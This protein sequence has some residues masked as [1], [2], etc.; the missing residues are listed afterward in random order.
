MRRLRHFT[1]NISSP[2][3]ELVSRIGTLLDAADLDSLIQLVPIRDTALRSQ[4]ARS[5]RFQNIADYE[6]AARVRIRDDAN[7]AAAVR[8]LIGPMPS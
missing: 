6:A 1:V 7:L 3:P 2:Y 4:V 8:M 5:L